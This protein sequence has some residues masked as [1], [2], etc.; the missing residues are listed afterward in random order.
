MSEK[1]ASKGDHKKK[2]IKLAQLVLE[3]QQDPILDRKL[4]K[5]LG[6]I[7]LMKHIE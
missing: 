6:Q 1:L 5:S 2:V 4:N 7:M 3:M